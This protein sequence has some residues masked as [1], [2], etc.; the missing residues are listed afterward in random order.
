[1]MSWPC[2]PQV[3][4]F[5]ASVS[6]GTRSTVLSCLQAVLR[7]LSGQ[8]SWEGFMRSIRISSWFAVVMA[9]LTASPALAAEKPVN[10]SLFPPIALVQ[11]KDGVS[12]VRLD[13]IYGK[14]A[15]VKVIDLGFVNQ[16]TTLSSGLQWGFVNVNDGNFKGLQLSGIG[17]NK[18]TT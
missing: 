11:P 17:Y 6:E 18:G 1:M 13:F 5:R 2:S 4:E 9:I 3:P 16:T 15:S 8:M 7:L 10:L 14:N 12:A